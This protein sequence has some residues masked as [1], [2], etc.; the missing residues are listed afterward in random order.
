MFV[1]RKAPL[2]KDPKIAKNCFFGHFDHVLTLIDP[3]KWLDFENFCSAR[4]PISGG[5][6]DQKIKI[7]DQKFNP[8]TPF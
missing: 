4:T 1:K 7:F 2:S 5:I 6:L 8:K 3:K